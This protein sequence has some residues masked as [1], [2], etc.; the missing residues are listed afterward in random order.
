MGRAFDVWFDGLTMMARGELGV[1]SAT[2]RWSFDGAQDDPSTELRTSGVEGW[3]V[4]GPSTWLRMMGGLGREV[5]GALT[6]A[7]IGAR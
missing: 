5:P 4:V 3:G 2:V 7:I 1:L 6:G